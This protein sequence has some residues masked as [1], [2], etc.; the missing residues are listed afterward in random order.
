MQAEQNDDWLNKA[1]E[2]L[3]EY[4]KASGFMDDI[5]DETDGQGL[6]DAIDSHDELMKTLAPILAQGRPLLHRP[7]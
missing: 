2:E 4:M 3:R 5:R 1:I 7:D 6:R